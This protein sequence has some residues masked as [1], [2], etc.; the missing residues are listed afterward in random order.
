MSRFHLLLVL[1]LLTG[2]APTEPKVPTPAPEP[3]GTILYLADHHL[4]LRSGGALRDLPELGQIESTAD[5]MLAP[6]GSTVL[7]VVREE[8]GAYLRT[9]AN[10]KVSSLPLAAPPGSLVAWAPDGAYVAYESEGDLMI[11]D[12]SGQ[13]ESLGL[14]GER[15][16]SFRWGPDAALVVRTQPEGAA[17][18][19]LWRWRPRR[20]WLALSDDALPQTGL[21]EWGLDGLSLAYVGRLSSGLPG[22]IVMREGPDG[23]MNRSEL[24]I[25]LPV[26]EVVLSGPTWSPDGGRLAAQVMEASSG[27]GTGWSLVMV[28]EGSTEVTRWAAPA[29]PCYIYG[30]WWLS[31]ERLLVQIAGPGCGKMVELDGRSGAVLRE[32]E[33]P[34][35]GLVHLGPGREWIAVES[36]ERPVGSTFIRVGKP[37]ERVEVG[38]GGL[39]GWTR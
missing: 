11:V 22:I 5:A 6:D 3:P 2:C 18:E 24:P 9:Y 39:V 1:L 38:F 36:R 16:V 30:Y 31:E 26:G 32:F 34:L 4:H 8:S 33:A 21:G 29:Y 19:R 10:G 17:L 7:A 25:D 20:P 12:R 27:R 23:A 13:A 14:H 37:S 35:K 15:L 28:S